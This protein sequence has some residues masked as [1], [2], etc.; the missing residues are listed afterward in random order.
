[1]LKSVTSQVEAGKPAEVLVVDNNSSDNTAK[2]A[3][4]FPIRYVFEPQ[5]GLS[6]ARNRGAREAQYE[7]LVYLDDDIRLMDEYVDN[8]LRLISEH[9]PDIWGGP[10]YAEY[11]IPKPSW[12]PDELETKTKGPTGFSATI[13][14]TGANYGIRKSILMSLGGFDPKWGM[15]GTKLWLMEERAVVDL[16]RSSRPR[17]EQRVYHCNDCGIY[18]HISADKMRP[19]YQ[20]RRAFLSNYSKT[21]LNFERSLVSPCNHLKTTLLRLCPETMHDYRRITADGRQPDRLFLVALAVV[22]RL[23]TITASIRALITKRSIVV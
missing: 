3:R 13:S 2:V 22:R 18:H 11:A 17:A 9:D 1:M 12:F 19:I 4:R 20:V 21:T 16:Y 8:M 10:I 23:G 6:V 5:Q 14:P 7:H 15:I